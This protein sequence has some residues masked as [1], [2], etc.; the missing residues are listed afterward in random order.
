MQDVL[1]IPCRPENE[2]RNSGVS[3]G[4]SSVQLD[5]CAIEITDLN[6][7]TINTICLAI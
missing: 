3:N 1:P 7:K 2:L 6:N 5:D 4:P